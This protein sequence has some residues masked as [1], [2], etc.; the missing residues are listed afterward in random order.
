MNTGVP[1]GGTL[2]ARN[3]ATLLFSVASVVS[4]YRE[5]CHSGGREVRGIKLV[6]I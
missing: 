2:E 5:K 6:D 3:F 4:R 1:F